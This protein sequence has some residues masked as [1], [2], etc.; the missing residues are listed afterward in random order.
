[1]TR[2][3]FTDSMPSVTGRIDGRMRDSALLACPS[4]QGAIEFMKN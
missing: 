1:M 4:P 2:R 3:E